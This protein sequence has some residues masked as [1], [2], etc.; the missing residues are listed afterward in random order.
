MSNEKLEKLAL[1]AVIIFVI[2]MLIYFKVRK[3]KA[4][5]T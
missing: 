4:I 5:V 1:P 3:Q 2:G